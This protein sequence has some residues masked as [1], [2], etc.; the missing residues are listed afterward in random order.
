[1]PNL[2]FPIIKYIIE[3]VNL[4]DLDVYLDTLDT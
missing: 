1:M 4:D 2:Y 3:K